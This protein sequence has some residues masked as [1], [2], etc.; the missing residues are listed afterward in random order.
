MIRCDLLG[1]LGEC[2]DVVGWQWVTTPWQ[3]SGRIVLW[4]HTTEKK[5]HKHIKHQIK[6]F[7]EF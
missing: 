7:A 4:E 3:R 2:L 1:C 5:K 6:W